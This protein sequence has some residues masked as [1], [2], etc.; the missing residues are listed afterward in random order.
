MWDLHCGNCLTSFWKLGF[1]R[2]FDGTV[3]GDTEKGMCIEI[4]MYLLSFFFSF[5]LFSWKSKKKKVCSSSSGCNAQFHLFKQV[6]SRTWQTYL[7]VS[8]VV[9]W[10][11]PKIWTANKENSYFCWSR[12]IWLFFLI[13]LFINMKNYTILLFSGGLSKICCTKLDLLQD[14]R[15]F[16]GE[17]FDMHVL[18][19]SER[20]RQSVTFNPLAT[21]R[22]AWSCAWNNEIVGRTHKM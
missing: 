17:L 19:N 12:K 9:L 20:R 6:W 1:R 22:C 2:A 13:A 8:Q 11:E 4:A 14:I 10:V 15:K 7:P 21:K 18:L 16:Y 3:N 5:L